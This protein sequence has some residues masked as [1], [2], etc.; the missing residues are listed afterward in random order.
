MVSFP[1]LLARPPARDCPVYSSRRCAVRQKAKDITNLLLDEKRMSS[2][3]RTRKDMRNRMAGQ[4]S[5][6][7]RPSRGSPPPRGGRGGGDDDLAAAIEASKRT[8]AEE[9]GKNKG[10]GGDSEFEE[11]LRLSREEDE[12]RR[13]ALAAG[14]GDNL[15]DEQQRYVLSPRDRRRARRP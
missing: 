10:G 14:A 9:A 8:A 6:S 1:S 4:P 12:R 2:Q 5:Q 7:D 15:F 13:R 3:R 11:A